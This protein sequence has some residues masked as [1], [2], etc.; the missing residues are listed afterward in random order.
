MEMLKG[1]I[2]GLGLRPGAEVLVV[3]LLA[4]RTSSF[5]VNCLSTKSVYLFAKTWC[6]HLRRRFNEFGRACWELQ[7]AFLGNGQL[8]DW[9][10]MSCWTQQDASAT[11]IESKRQYIQGLFLKASC[12][13]S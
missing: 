10:F 6:A 4:S 11:E 5:R 13:A 2:E 12:V 9:R 7:K 1:L 3:E 8:Q